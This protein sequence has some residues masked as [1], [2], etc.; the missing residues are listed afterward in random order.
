MKKNI[1]L[2]LYLFLLFPTS[3]SLAGYMGVI[4]ADP[5][6]ESCQIF[7]DGKKVSC[8]TR[9][10]Y[11]G[12]RL[13]P[14]LP[15]EQLKVSLASIAIMN[16]DEL[17]G[18]WI[19]A[20][21][22]EIDDGAIRSFID[23][24]LG[25]E[26]HY[27]AITAVRGTS[28]DRTEAFLKAIKVTPP[29][30]ATALPNVPIVFRWRKGEGEE[31]VIEDDSEKVVFSHA[32]EKTGTYELL[33]AKVGLQPGQQYTWYYRGDVL[34][35]HYRLNLIDPDMEANQVVASELKKLP[36]INSVDDAIYTAAY[37]QVIS[38]LSESLDLYWLSYQVL[39]RSFDGLSADQKTKLL[40]LISRYY[41]KTKMMN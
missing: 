37:L 4:E 29:S 1:L 41:D 3:Y 9:V 30:E 31:L 32:L 17:G 14:G 21:G 13:H 7:R 8:N 25:K 2:A 23:N 5:L 28:G 20:A 24:F 36:E 11:L 16:V 38:D 18:F 27:V 12:D 33:P 26:E 19:Q 22:Q 34:E 15:I 39:P 35:E 6:P 10:L 40:N